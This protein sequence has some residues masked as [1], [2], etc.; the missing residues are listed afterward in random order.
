LKNKTFENIL[1]IKMENNKKQNNNIQKELLIYNE[2]VRNFKLQFDTYDSIDSKLKIFLGFM[3]GFLT[4]IMGYFKFELAYS[5]YLETGVLCLILISIFY[6][7]KGI[8]TKPYY[9]DPKPED[10]DGK[11]SQKAY[12]DLIKQLTADI[13]NAYKKNRNTHDKKVKDFKVSITL[14]IIGFYLLIILKILETLL[15]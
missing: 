12:I 3:V 14:F 4:F 1:D 9:F 6:L 10:V 5:Q 2:V 8:W 13:V 7:I 15:K 11:Y